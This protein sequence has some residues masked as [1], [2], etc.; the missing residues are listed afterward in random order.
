MVPWAF[1]VLLWLCFLLQLPCAQETLGYLI[2]FVNAGQW[3]DAQKLLAAWIQAWGQMGGLAELFD[4]A[5]KE[6]HPLQKV[7]ST[8]WMSLCSVSKH[9]CVSAVLVLI[10]INMHA[11]EENLQLMCLHLQY[12]RLSVPSKLVPVPSS[13]HSNHGVVDE[14]VLCVFG[15]LFDIQLQAIAQLTCAMAAS[16]LAPVTCR[17]QQAFLCER[18]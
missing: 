9:S 3:E 4:M 1:I 13:Y 17:L 7:L 14:C 12:S 5:A 8:P 11:A 2:S 10:V 6:I 16:H 15:T 18:K